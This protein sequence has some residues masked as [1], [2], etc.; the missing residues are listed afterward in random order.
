MK[1]YLFYL[2]A[3]FLFSNCT[4]TEED[5]IKDSF[6]DYVHM[7]FDDPDQMEEVIFVSK[8]DTITIDSI[9]SVYQDMLN[10]T[11]KMSNYLQEQDSLIKI[12]LEEVAGDQVLALYCTY[13]PDNSYVK[14]FS[15]EL[16]NYYNYLYESIEDP[17]AYFRKDKY[18]KE[19]N[20]F[21]SDTTIRYSQYIKRTLKYRIQK[22][23]GRKIDSIYYYYKDNGEPY[24]SYKDISLED[25][26]PICVKIAKSF[27]GLCGEFEEMRARYDNNQKLLQAYE[28]LSGHVYDD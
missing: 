11:T 26:N 28:L 16:R 7:N 6:N 14:K 27:T 3:L 15:K 4:K 20:A 24:F 13:N 12:V 21:L 18:S 25:F 9:M 5:K 19:M 10:N 23:E 8:P 2:L 17:S 1:K 22:S